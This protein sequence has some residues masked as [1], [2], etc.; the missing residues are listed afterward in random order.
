MH[1]QGCP[2]CGTRANKWCFNDGMFLDTL[3]VF[4]EETQASGTPCLGCSGRPM[5]LS[6]VHETIGGHPRQPSFRWCQLTIRSS[7]SNR[8]VV[9][10][11]QERERKEEKKIEKGKR[12]YTS[13]ALLMLPPL[14]F[15]ATHASVV[16]RKNT[17]S[18]TILTTMAPR[19]I[20]WCWT[21]QPG[22]QSAH[23]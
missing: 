3:Q 17:D 22:G 21:P 23:W 15:Q 1:H 11:Q 14:F 20:L 10:W 13:N 8:L 18:E 5:D 2:L 9:A 16:W 6:P 7:W 4:T 12:S 19:A